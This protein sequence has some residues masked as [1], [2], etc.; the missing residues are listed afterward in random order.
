M[1]VIGLAVVGL[2]C[3]SVSAEAC[4]WGGNAYRIGAN[5]GTRLIQIN[6]ACTELKISYITTPNEARKVAMRQKGK[7]WIADLT[8]SF[9]LSFGPNGRSLKLRQGGRSDRMT[10]VKVNK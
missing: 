10:V 4:P 6:P 8:K 7:R 1:R 5:N 3:F 2:L 9:E